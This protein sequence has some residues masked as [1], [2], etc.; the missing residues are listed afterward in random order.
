MWHRSR[1][2]RY[3]QQLPGKIFLTAVLAQVLVIAGCSQPVVEVPT[4]VQPIKIFTLGKPDSSA[5]RDYPGTIQASQDAR[6]G[7]EVAGRIVEFLVQEGDLVQAGQVLARLDPRDYENQRRVAQANNNK[8]VADLNRSLELQRLNSGAVAEADLE[9]DRRAAEVTEAKLEI[10]EKAVEDTELRASFGGL[11]AR[12]LVP[13]FANV[14]AKEPVVILQDVSQLE[15]E[16]SVPERDIIQRRA[17]NRRTREELSEAIDPV[18]IVSALPDREFPAVITE[19]ATTADPVTR[20]FPVTLRFQRPQDVNILPGM[21]ARVRLV[22]SPEL[23]W[24]VPVSAVQADADD[25]PY[26]WKVDPESMTVTRAP[27]AVAQL[28]GDRLQLTEGVAAGE[29]VAISGVQQLREGMQVRAYQ[30]PPQSSP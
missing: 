21:T 25:Q 2:I 8:A 22:V 28:T 26:V 23:A 24:A 10:A 15:I 20:T 12:K 16:I 29:Q 30:G 3:V 5:T 18:V 13:D 4:A 14:Q 17:V 6:Q 19:F 27:V 9:Q 11:V 1:G 7:F